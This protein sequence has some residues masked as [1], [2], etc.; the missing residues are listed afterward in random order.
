MYLG[1][2]GFGI[3]KV[4][5]VGGLGGSGIFGGH[6]LTDRLVIMSLIRNI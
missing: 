5:E 6:D 1:R 3:K 4:E 2:E